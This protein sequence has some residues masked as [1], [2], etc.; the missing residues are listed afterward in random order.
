MPAAILAHKLFSFTVMVMAVPLDVVFTVILKR[1][2]NAN[3]EGLCSLQLD[4]GRL[5][6]NTFWQIDTA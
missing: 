2:V 6:E 5:P 1:R 4:Y 3:A